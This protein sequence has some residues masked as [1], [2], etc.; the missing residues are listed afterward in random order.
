VKADTGPAL[1]YSSGYG[2]MILAYK[3]AT[4]HQVDY[5]RWTGG[6]T[7][8]GPTALPSASSIPS[9]ALAWDNFTLYA[10]WPRSAKT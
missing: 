1:A 3:A 9:P 7:S 5:V 8:Y 4:N 6:N 2:K 10:A